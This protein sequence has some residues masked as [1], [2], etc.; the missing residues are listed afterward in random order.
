MGFVRHLIYYT[1]WRAIC[2]SIIKSLLYLR[3]EWGGWG[4]GRVILIKVA[5]LNNKKILNIHIEV[6]NYIS[7]NYF[8]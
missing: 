8:L 5:F 3:L 4:G 2:F 1:K 7:L 6:L